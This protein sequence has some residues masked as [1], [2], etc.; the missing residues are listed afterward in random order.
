MRRRASVDP[1]SRVDLLHCNRIRRQVC[2]H[3][4][5]MDLHVHCAPDAL[6]AEVLGLPRLRPHFTR[7]DSLLPA[8]RL[9][10]LA[11]GHP[12]G[13]FATWRGLACLVCVP[14]E[15]AAAKRT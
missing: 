15:A 12:G 5:L 11:F 3:P 2:G 8:D 1:C 13:A 9:G 6:P 14:P 7:S 4:V 10:L